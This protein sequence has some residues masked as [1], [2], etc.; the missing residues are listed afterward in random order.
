MKYIAILCVISFLT[1]CSPPTDSRNNV[2]NFGDTVHINNTQIDGTVIRYCSCA[3]MVVILYAD[4]FGQMHEME[5]ST[6]LLT[7][8]P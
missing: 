2:V 1:S 7:K 3:N 4:D 8:I 5:I 6:R